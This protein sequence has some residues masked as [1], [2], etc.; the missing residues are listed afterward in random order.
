MK[1]LKPEG[2]NLG[3]GFSKKKKENLG[4]GDLIDPGDPMEAVDSK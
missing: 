4:E 1:W 3:E 2:E